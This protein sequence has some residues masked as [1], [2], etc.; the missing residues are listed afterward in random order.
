MVKK[1]VF[2]TFILTLC[3]L[4]PTMFIITACGNNHEHTF[5]TEW[6]T[7]ETHHWYSA[8]C[9]HVDEK[10]A[11]GEHTV[12]TWSVK[13]EAGKHVDKVEQGACTVCERV[14]ERTVPNTATHT[15][16]TTWSKNST[17]HWRESTCEGHTPALKSEVANHTFG[18]PVIKRNADYGVNRVEE[19]ECT[20]CEFK[21]EYEVPNTALAP[22]TNT[23]T[24]NSFGFTYNAK[25]QKINDYVSALNT[26]GMEIKYRGV[27]DTV[28]SESTTAPTNAGSYEYI[29]TIPATAEWVK[30]E[31]TGR[32]EIAQ[33][34][35]QCPNLLVTR[36]VGDQIKT[37]ILHEIDVSSIDGFDDISEVRLVHVDNSFG[38]G[39]TKNINK[40]KIKCDNSNFKINLPSGNIDLVVAD[41]DNEFGLKITSMPTPVTYYEGTIL[42]GSVKVGDTMKIVGTNDSNSIAMFNVTITG[43]EYRYFDTNTSAVTY[44]STN[45]ATKGEIVRI[46]LSKNTS[47]NMK[48]YAFIISPKAIGT[49]NQY[50]QSQSVEADFQGSEFMA[51]SVTIQTNATNQLTISNSDSCNVKVFNALTGE[52]IVLTDNSF[53]VEDGTQIIIVVKQVV[54]AGKHQIKIETV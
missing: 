54:S 44:I 41:A 29:I 46:T 48:S 30:G 13:T 39:R 26:T 47:D 31:K 16:S 3:L 49:I 12:A 45:Q 43:I 6:T 11:Y 38:I 9:E 2:L 32:F 34:T 18:T 37:N 36:L 10:D 1:K 14:I 15:Y 40:D 8:T 19:Q 23:I 53:Q 5:S 4:V 22:K 27:G 51:F 28:Y 33:Y 17:Q 20:V 52:E 50:Q 24:M 25:A 35:L 7:N 21:K 42:H